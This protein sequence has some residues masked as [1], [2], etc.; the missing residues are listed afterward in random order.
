M[1]VLFALRRAKQFHGSNPAGGGF[2]WSEFYEVV[3][4]KAAF[5]RSLGIGKGDRVGVWMLNSHEYLELYFATA[6]A[7]IAIV[8]INTRWHVNDVD[9]TLADSGAKAL[10]VD[11][12]LAAKTGGLKH[13]PRILY[14]CEE[15]DA[16]VSF[17]EPDPNDLLGLF[18]TSGT[19]GGPKGVMLTHSNLWSNAVQ[20]MM[21]TGIAQG[22]LAAFGADVSCGR[23]VDGVHA[24]DA[25]Q[26]EFLFAGVRS[27][28]VS[29]ACRD[30]SGD[31]YDPGSD[32]DQHG[33]ASS[34]VCRFRSV[35]L[36]QDFVWRVANAGAS[37]RVG[38][39]QASASGVYSGL[40]D[41]GG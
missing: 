35:Q 9:F 36:A 26:R 31:R 11:R 8:P 39:A 10:F 2:T 3:Y 14:S 16:H 23:F 19:T 13:A 41:D 15:S 34:F 18:Y 6:I 24:R 27:G 22:C 1:N 38:D 37:D 40:W 21:A 17:D 25:R 30:A 5:L 32:D 4:R 12:N 28:D 7:G 33:V 20:T 29:E